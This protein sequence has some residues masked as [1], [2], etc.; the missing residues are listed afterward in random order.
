[1]SDS[2]SI[3][4]RNTGLRSTYRLSL[5]ELKEILRD[6]R[7]IITLVAMPLLVYP[8][9]SILL[10]KFYFAAANT[11]DEI[12]YKFVF[13]QVIVDDDGKQ[14][15]EEESV[16]KKISEKELIDGF[17]ENYINFGE[18]YVFH[19][20][21][22]PPEKILKPL[23]A[24]NVDPR[25]V[26]AFERRY[27]DENLLWLRE[28]DDA[29]LEKLV[30]SG[31][32]DV[33][34]RI[35]RGSRRNS[36]IEIIQLKSG[37]SAN[38]ATYL[39]KRIDATN[40]VVSRLQ[41]SRS[42]LFW[43]GKQYE[44]T[45]LESDAVAASISMS[46]LVPLILILMTV[47]GA[48]YPAIDLTAGERERGTLEALIAAPV[49]RFQVLFAKFVGVLTVAMLTA[50]VN[51]IGMFGT[52]AIFGLL[53]MLFG[54]GAFG[55]L[56]LFQIFT[57]LLLFAAFFSAVLLAITSFARSFKEA[58]AYIVPVTLISIIPGIISLSPELKFSGVFT[59]IPL[60][61]IVLL[62][63]EIMEGTATYIPAIVAITSTTL[64]GIAALSVAATIF[65]SDSILYGNQSSWRSMIRRPAQ[66]S[67]EISL[68]RS[69]ACLAVLFPLSFISLALVGRV[70]QW[71]AA[72][73]GI[74]VDKLAY[75]V[76]LVPFVIS[77][78]VVF[79]FVPILFLWHGR[80][81]LLESLKFKGASPWAFAAAILIGVCLWPLTGQLVE[82]VNNLAANGASEEPAW[83]TE[84]LA[85]AK[86]IVEQWR[87][88]PP[89]LIICCFAIVPAVCEEFYFRGMLLRSIARRQRAG[90]AVLSS[91]LVFGIFHT[92]SLTDLSSQKFLPSF[93]AG[94]VL[95]IVALRSG[96]II[97]GILLHALNNGIL[98]SLAYYEDKLVEQKWIDSTQGGLPI[99][100]LVSAGVGVAGGI[101]ILFLF[102]GNRAND[103]ADAKVDSE[104]KPAADPV[105]TRMDAKPF[106]NEID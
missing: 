61:N 104:L 36:R 19:E 35:F 16:D 65:G 18:G 57:L 66:S 39:R 32:A 53:P 23:T 106:E 33:G 97:P 74:E 49:P 37:V 26:G 28:K 58:Q 81:R 76:Q 95:A 21:D 14:I 62:A 45:S 88:E 71:V 42:G 70:P 43:L 27:F 47:T 15:S 20:L 80:I 99:W 55:W 48:V 63:R 46:S 13:D 100:A 25:F 77:T 1:M 4:I 91:A 31:K 78:T 79:V 60:V 51:M 34:I 87:T 90:V 17:I 30:E 56:P 85:K 69:M 24:E 44:T 92:L 103:Q 94:I 5:K 64:Y 40:H 3:R 2:K 68:A 50:I 22:F 59:V 12:V 8:L 54:D 67:V 102:P 38:A 101:L 83:K 7:T 72:S 41:L 29:E 9:L 11:S 105:S 86:K 93:V 73:Q 98:V 75:W 96:S 84:L 82:T 10:Q 89:W 52:L 6:R